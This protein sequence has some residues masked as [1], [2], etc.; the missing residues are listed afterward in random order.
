MRQL[1]ANL[2]RQRWAAPVA[3][4]PKLRAPELKDV[5]P[6]LITLP[7]ILVHAPALRVPAKEDT[8]RPVV[9]GIRAVDYT[10]FRTRDAKQQR[11]L[12]DLLDLAS[13][14]QAEGNPTLA[15]KIRRET[16]RALTRDL[17]PLE[18][19]MDRWIAARTAVGTEICGCSSH[20]Q[21]RCP[22][23][24]RLLAPVQTE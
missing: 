23:P 10:K 4:V 22:A 12:H 8:I 24:L 11:E 5:D 19:A 6:D 21:V 16:Y 17:T 20:A 14:T 18:R 15:K 1:V 9:G 2:V 3:T 13:L 7:P